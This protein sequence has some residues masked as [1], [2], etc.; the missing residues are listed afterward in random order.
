MAA[1]MKK[2]KI[3]NVQFMKNVLLF[4]KNS[5]FVPFSRAYNKIN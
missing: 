2:K 1:K 5:V 4:E 3:K